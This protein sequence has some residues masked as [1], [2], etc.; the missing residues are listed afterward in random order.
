M[1]KGGGGSH[2]R[3]YASLVQQQGTALI[4][5]GSR[6]D[7]GGWYQNPLEGDAGRSSP[8]PRKRKVPKGMGIKT[9]ALRQTLEG[10]SRPAA[11][12]RP[13]NA[14]ASRLRR[15]ESGP[16]RHG[17]VRRIGKPPRC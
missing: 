2:G 12:A 9:S 3:L 16:S 8:P 13:G 4:R 17:E 1:G 7:S 14:R 10:S 5:Q 6:C 15:F 11:G